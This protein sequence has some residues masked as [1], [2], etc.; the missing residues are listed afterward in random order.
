VVD[1]GLEDLLIYVLQHHSNERNVRLAP[2]ID[3]GV[4]G[5]IAVFDDGIR[6][7]LG[8]IWTPEGKFRGG[9]LFAVNGVSQS[10][11]TSCATSRIFSYN[12][13]LHPG[14]AC[15]HWFLPFTGRGLDILGFARNKS[16][17]IICP[18]SRKEHCTK[19]T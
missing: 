2:A 18:K 3:C 15:M 11:S 1:L 9:L 17:T 19:G 8:Y 4:L 14:P 10:W 12:I 5:S 6:R 7:I 16:Q 13:H